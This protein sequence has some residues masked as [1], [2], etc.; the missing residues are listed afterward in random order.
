MV[1]FGKEFGLDPDRKKI[2]SGI[3]NFSIIRIRITESKKEVET[4]IKTA[5]GDKL[6]KGHYKIAQIDVKADANGEI[7]KYYSPNGPI[8]SACDEILTKYGKDKDGNLKEPVHVMEVKEIQP[9]DATKNPYLCF[10]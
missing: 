3:G 10:T 1:E 7:L 8:V 5:E 9:A 6:V 4:R 2:E